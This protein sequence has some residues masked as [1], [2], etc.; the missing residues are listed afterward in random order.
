MLAVKNRCI[1]AKNSK[2]KATRRNIA[3][4]KKS[5]TESRLGRTDTR[6]AVFA[7]HHYRATPLMAALL[8][9]NFEAAAT[10]IDE[11]AKL[12]LQNSRGKTVAWSE[13]RVFI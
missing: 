11:G 2:N 8:C 6:L 3:A 10:L 12:H 4:Q 1:S 9:G 5:L 7:Y 13:N